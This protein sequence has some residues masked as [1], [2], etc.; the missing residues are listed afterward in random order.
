MNVQKNEETKFLEI[1][2]TV[3]W[4]AE[5]QSFLFSYNLEDK[6]WWDWIHVSYPDF[7]TIR[8]LVKVRKQVIIV[9]LE[10]LK[11]K[12][13]IKIICNFALAKANSV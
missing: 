10:R 6:F 2:V 13:I 4:L 8:Y 1:S 11:N 9:L 5:N 3:V 7:T 12:E